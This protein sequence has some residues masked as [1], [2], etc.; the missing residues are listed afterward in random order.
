M[1]KSLNSK[2]LFVP[3]SH[4]DW[5]EDN[6]ISAKIDS[7]KVALDLDVQIKGDQTSECLISYNLPNGDTNSLR[8]E[9]IDAYRES[10]SAN[11]AD[12]T[13][14]F[15]ITAFAANVTTEIPNQEGFCRFIK[16]IND[17]LKSNAS[18][19]KVFIRIDVVA[20]GRRKKSKSTDYNF[21]I[22]Y[23]VTGFYSYFEKLV[24]GNS[25]FENLIKVNFTSIQYNEVENTFFVYFD[26]RA[27]DM[28]KRTENLAL[29]FPYEE[30]KLATK[31]FKQA[32]QAGCVTNN[33]PQERA[34]SELA[35]EP[36][37]EKPALEDKKSYELPKIQTY[38]KSIM[39]RVRSFFNL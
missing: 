13:Y 28:F 12:I 23:E 6:I 14:P 36:A 18:D 37:L 3:Q 25:E 32:H 2:V 35:K 15:R 4:R 7:S 1:P 8:I 10:K 20:T 38:C 30:V 31:S 19:F 5:I 34:D 27:E 26:D 21:V 22:D 24:V 11:D 16:S 39:P 9:D 33:V 17:S 29:Q